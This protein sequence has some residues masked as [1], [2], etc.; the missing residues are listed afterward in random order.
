MG[1]FADASKPESAVLR[2]ALNAEPAVVETLNGN[3]PLQRC[4][5]TTTDGFGH[6]WTWRLK[7]Y[8][9]TLHLSIFYDLLSKFGLNRQL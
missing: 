4:S 3:R 8:G 9:K 7:G 6:F 2:L 1:S 5:V